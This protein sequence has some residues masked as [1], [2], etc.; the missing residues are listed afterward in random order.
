MDIKDIIWIDP[1]RCGGAPCFRGTRVP[2]QILTDYLEAGETVD[3][4]L[5]QYPSLPRQMVMAY[6]DLAQ[7]HAVEHAA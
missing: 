1:E 5:R 7:K 3:E 4:F 6:L 2:V